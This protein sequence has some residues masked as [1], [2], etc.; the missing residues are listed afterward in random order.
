MKNFIIAS[1]VGISAALPLPANAEISKTP[2]NSTIVNG[3]DFGPL[4][5]LVGTWKTAEP[6]GT[7]VAPGKDGSDVGKGGTAV[8]PY[9]EVM[10]FEPAAD[11]TNA[12]DQYLA[13]MYYK[14]EVFRV[15]DNGKFH[16][17]R[18]YLT[19]D[20]KNNTV[21]NTF[22][23]PRAVCVVAEGPAG[24]TMSLETKG[25]GVAESDYMSKNDKT[26]KFSF[27]IDLSGDQ[28][29]YTQVTSL[30]VYGEPFEHVDTST[31]EKVK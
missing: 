25:N 27:D 16:D 31:L 19:Y 1:L 3:L 26:M 24:E 28:L 20:K 5:K 11:A 18:G 4:A 10:T 30:Q 12:S 21:Y 29:Q 14:H 15:R 23:I 13:A 22:C 6:G 17:Q 7:D 8:E 9:Y 2:E